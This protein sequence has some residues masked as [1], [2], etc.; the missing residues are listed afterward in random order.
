MVPQAALHHAS[1]GMTPDA[2]FAFGTIIVLIV[3]L[4]LAAFVFSK[5]RNTSGIP[6]SPHY[7]PQRHLHDDC[8]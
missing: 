4:N 1:Q 5:R 7:H 6:K 2:W 3:V 8:H